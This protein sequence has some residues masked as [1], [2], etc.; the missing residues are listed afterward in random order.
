MKPKYLV[1]MAIILVFI[2]F[3]VFNLKKSLTPYVSFSEAVKT[4]AV[5][6]VKGVRVVGS[7]AF[8]P[9]NKLFRFKISDDHGKELEVVYHGVKP[10]NFEQ[11]T[12]V[13]VIGRYMSGKFEA[14]QLL[15]KCPSKYQAEGA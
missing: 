4:D 9:D 3:A 5:V 11:A 10:S 15:V 7:E 6:Q 2:I 13:V 8:E 12:Q 14:D 1:G